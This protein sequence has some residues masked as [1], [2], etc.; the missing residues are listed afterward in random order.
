LFYFHRVLREILKALSQDDF[1]FV[2]TE[3]EFYED[4][5]GVPGKHLPQSVGGRHIKT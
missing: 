4:I 1:I 5:D 3:Q 2:K